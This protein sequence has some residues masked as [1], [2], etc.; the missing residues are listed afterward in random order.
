MKLNERQSSNFWKKVK[1]TD[2]CWIWTA[3]KD[4]DGYGTI[5]INPQNRRSHVVSYL[6]HGGHIPD[7]YVMHHDCKNKSCVNPA[8]LRAVTQRE[9]LHADDTINRRNAAKTHCPHGHEY[10]PENTKYNN[11]NERRCQTC[12]REQTRRASKAYRQRKKNGKV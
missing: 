8:H 6:I 12:V 9:N 4:R 10:T 11:K 5:Y 2:T 1:K 3:Y 7:G